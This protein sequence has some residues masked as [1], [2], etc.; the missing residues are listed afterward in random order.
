[1]SLITGGT[2]HKKQLLNPHS[3]LPI[4]HFPLFTPSHAIYAVITSNETFLPSSFPP[5]FLYQ[6]HGCMW[7]PLHQTNNMYSCVCVC[8]CRISSASWSLHVSISTPLTQ[9]LSRR[10]ISA[11]VSMTWSLL[12]I[13]LSLVTP[14]VSSHSGT[15]SRE[16][17]YIYLQS[18]FS[19]LSLS[20]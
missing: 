18:F 20:L 10:K 12:R 16:Y 3:S 15:S 9:L 11:N 8:V 17:I 14:G 5:H 13:S 19:I 2:L 1:M 4:F 7:Y 6:L